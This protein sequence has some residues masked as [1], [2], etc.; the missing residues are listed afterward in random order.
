MSFYLK[1]IG[2]YSKRDLPNIIS[3]SKTVIACD[4]I[5]SICDYV[6]A[7]HIRVAELPRW[8]DTAL[9]TNRLFLFEH[10]GSECS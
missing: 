5:R 9:S 6:A 1:Y 7:F 4:K 10:V 2:I 3:T 8:R